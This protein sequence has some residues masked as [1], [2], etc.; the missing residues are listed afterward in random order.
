MQAAFD[1]RREI[2][3]NAARKRFMS[4]YF[5]FNEFKNLYPEE[6]TRLVYEYRAYVFF[7]EQFFKIYAKMR[8]EDYRRSVN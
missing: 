2:A 4:S 5:S 3:M 7:M 8:F 1:I 6:I